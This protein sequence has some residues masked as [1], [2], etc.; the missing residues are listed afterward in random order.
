MEFKIRHE[1][2]VVSGTFEGDIEY[3]TE[4]RDL[5]KSIAPKYIEFLSNYEDDIFETLKKLPYC[6][7]ALILQSILYTILYRNSNKDLY[8]FESDSGLIKIGIS[9]DVDKRIVQVSN[10]V[11]SKLKLIK[12]LKGCC[13]YER[14]L[15]KIFEDINIPYMLQTEWFHPTTDL[16]SFIERLS[17]KNITNLCQKRLKKVTGRKKIS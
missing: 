10:Q 7:G 13:Q 14:D 3:F 6:E 2:F 16:I 15:H 12:V 11:K 8:F 1:D 4:C 17:E 5:S 9:Q